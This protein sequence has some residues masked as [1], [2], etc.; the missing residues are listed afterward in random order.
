M[1]L[2]ESL[3][4]SLSKGNQAPAVAVS[5][6]LR[7]A[8]QLETG[9]VQWLT[10][11]TL[12]CN[13]QQKQ[14]RRTI[15]RKENISSNMLSLLS[16]VCSLFFNKL[17]NLSGHRLH[18]IN[19]Y[20]LEMFQVKKNAYKSIWAIAFIKKFVIIT[21]SLKARQ[22]E[23]ILHPRYHSNGHASQGQVRM[24]LWARSLLGSPMWITGMP[25]FRISSATAPRTLVGIWER[26]ATRSQTHTLM[27]DTK[28][29]AMSIIIFMLSFYMVLKLTQGI[30]HTV[31]SSWKQLQ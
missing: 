25:A 9:Q 11:P 29:L 1:N 8:T 16:A 10:S 14:E 30:P 15:S 7:A 19:I 28:T 3:V 31:D 2:A 4:H 5:S 12:Q 22:R 24:K 17:F 26:R 27:W 21:V 20:L 13:R 6:V 18:F 23:R